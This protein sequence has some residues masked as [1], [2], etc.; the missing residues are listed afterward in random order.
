MDELTRLRRTHHH[1]L[2][3]TTTTVLCT[4]VAGVSVACRSRSSSFQ[5][6]D[7]LTAIC[8]MFMFI[9]IV[10]TWI[11]SILMNGHVKRLAQSQVLV[12]VEGE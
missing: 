12:P 9:G 2:R 10:F 7:R 3:M 1:L 4:V 8:V 11:M 5:I 6:G